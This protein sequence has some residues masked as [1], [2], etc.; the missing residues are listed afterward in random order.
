MVLRFAA[1][2]D[3]AVEL[4]VARHLHFERFRQRVDDRDAD[5]VQAAR[6][7]VGLAVEFAAGVQDRHDDLE[8]AVALVLGVRPDRDAA[9]VVGD[10]QK[11]V[12]GKLDLDPRRMAGDRLVHGVVDHL[13]EQVMHRLFVG[14]AD[15]HARAAADRLKAFQDLDVMFAVAAVLGRLSCARRFY[16]HFAV[17]F[18]KEV[19]L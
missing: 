3:H 11:S 17:E 15:V 13:G 10:R 12:R 4:L 5:A 8:R 1:R 2:E 19:S 14:A 7:V 18:R 16:D 6:G 9:A